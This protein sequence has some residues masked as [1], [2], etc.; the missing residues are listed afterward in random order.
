VTDRERTAYAVLAAWISA[1]GC[2]PSTVELGREL[3][4]SPQSAY[5]YLRT[6]R[7]TGLIAFDRSLA[8]L[9]IRAKLPTPSGWCS[10][11]GAAIPGG[12]KTEKSTPP[13]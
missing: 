10:A 5:A 1:K 13:E 12:E 9:E 4:V 7:A 3:G 11:C 2:A 8:N 6:L